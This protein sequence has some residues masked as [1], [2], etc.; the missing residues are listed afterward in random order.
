MIT[1]FSVLM[2]VYYKESAKHL[3]A[4]LSSL[5]AQ[6]R[7]ADEIVLVEDG[8]LTEPLYDV[9]KHFQ[10]LYAS[11]KV[12]PLKKNVGTG[13]A[14][15]EGLKHCSFDVVARMD[16]DDI[17]YPT[18][19]EKQLDFLNAHPEIDVVGSYTTEF[20]EDKQGKRIVLS[21]KKFPHTAEENNIYSRKRCPFEHPAVMFRKQAVIGAGGYQHC[22]L[23][24][25]YH[26][27]ARMI[28]NGSKF[29]NLQEPLLYFRMT[30]D[31]FKRRGGF[32]YAIT[33]CKALYM[34]RRIGFLS[35]HQF[36]FDVITRFPVRVMP[37]YL[38]KW[39]Y[40][41]FLRK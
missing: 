26:L 38:R 25:D 20:T 28:M 18:R 24:E 19:F 11:L 33:E 39:V 3:H 10:S 9:I 34:F 30:E 23:F 35:L 40:K 41:T 17:C 15:N 6:T 4:S 8:P 1:K 22:L 29:Y 32:R 14:L 12:I 7:N 31:S 13:R 37:C 21:T 16:S 27:W 36:L 5:F 2:P